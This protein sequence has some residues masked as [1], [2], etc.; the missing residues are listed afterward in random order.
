MRCFSFFVLFALLCVCGSTG[1]GD[2]SHA[3]G[4]TGYMIREAMFAQAS[5]YAPE[6]YAEAVVLQSAA[7]KR[8]RGTHAKGRS[9]TQ[10]MALTRQAYTLAKEARDVALAARGLKVSY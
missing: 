4:D 10:A 6:K 2:L 7:K 5:R 8:M 3:I 9:E 1:A